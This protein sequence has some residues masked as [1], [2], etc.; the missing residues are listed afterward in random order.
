VVAAIAALVPALVPSPVSL[1]AV[2]TQC[3]RRDDESLFNALMHRIGGHEIDIAALS[4][5]VG[6][7]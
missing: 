3:A 1:A 5:T 4:A 6:G 7:A 2:C